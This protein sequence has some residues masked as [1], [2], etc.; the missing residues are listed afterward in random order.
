MA[1]STVAVEV[2]ELVK[3]YP[4]RDV[5][6]VDGLSFAVAEGE[7]F[8]LLGPNGAGKTTTVGVLTTRVQATSGQAILAGID[9]RRDP[10]A[11][12]ARLAVVPQRSNL[13][14]ALT[15]RQ[16]LTFHA[17]Y[18]GVGR[19]ERNDRAAALLE[20]FGLGDQADIKV[21]WYSGGMA[22]RLMIARAL[23]HEPEV[24]FL[25]EPTTGLDPQARLFVWDR[26]RELR[27]RG[28]T[29]VLTTHDMDEAAELTDRVGIVDHGRLL[30]LDP[31]GALVRGLSGQ[32]VLELTVL[33]GEADSVDALI[34]ALVEIDGVDKAER[35]KQGAPSFAGAGGGFPGGFPGFGGGA[36]GAGAARPSAAVA[37]VVPGAV[38]PVQLRL[39]L[40]VE[41]ASMLGPVVIILAARS[42]ALTDVHIGEPSLEDVFIE[43]TGR[44]LR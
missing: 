2:V 15:P 19:T 28:V 10:V 27:E 44:G 30:A 24:L 20:Q 40:T 41:P 43:L 14:R 35:V 23:I 34:D 22:Q 9:V 3:R 11:A 25:D 7:V 37:T 42:A 12:R 21:D 17:A 36:P 4:K 5:N 1:D 8:G 33:P 31:P 6:A 38:A 29:I 16:N 18:H 13:D 39:Y 26:I 32:S